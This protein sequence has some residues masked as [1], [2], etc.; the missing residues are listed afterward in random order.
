MTRFTNE[1]TSESESGLSAPPDYTP[2]HPVTLMRLRTGL[3]SSVDPL[4]AWDKDNS[5]L[6]CF[7]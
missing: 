4:L 1:S 6:S 3:F 7:N 2:P 5:A